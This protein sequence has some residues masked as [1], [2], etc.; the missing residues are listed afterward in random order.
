MGQFE[1]VA[2][3]QIPLY[4]RDDVVWGIASDVEAMARVGRNALPDGRASL[5]DSQK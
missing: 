2:E 5:A 3:K 4:T 1:P